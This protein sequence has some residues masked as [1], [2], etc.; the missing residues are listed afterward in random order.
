MTAII[1]TI[2][3]PVF[4]AIDISKLKHDVLVKHPDG[5]TNTFQV[6]NNYSDFD[7]FC[8]YLA[9]LNSKCHI[10]LEPTADYHRLIA[11]R[12]LESGH[13]VFL[14]STVA[15]AR[16]R[17][18]IFNSRDKNDIKDAKVI[19]HLLESGITQHYHDPLTNDLND[20]QELANTYAVIAYRRTQVLHSLKNHYIT[21]YFPE[22]EKYL[23]STRALW[24]TQTFTRFPT[25][26]SISTLSMSKFI[27]IASPLVGRKVRKNQWLEELY[28]TASHS[29]GLPVSETSVAARMFALMLSEYER[30]TLIRQQIQDTADT[31]LSSN[32]DYELLKSIPGVG[33]VI[34][35]S[36]LA[37]GGDLR[38]FKHHKQFLKF[39]GFDLA[40][41]QSG[42]YKSKSSLSKRGNARLRLVFWQAA[43]V[44]IR[45]TENSFRNK[46]TRYIKANTD[47]ADNRRK[48]R[49]AVAAKLARVAYSIVKSGKPYRPYFESALPGG[50]IP[51]IGS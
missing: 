26:G 23:H 38:R 48:A 2:S 47:T 33:P 31:V 8:G 17:E 11:W 16:A 13:E 44:A 40:T 20:L 34:A 12:L 3:A 29:I 5:K 14:V 51:Q 28:N 41:H 24:F 35:L 37:E 32:P 1:S 7:K 9:S 42:K 46:Y 43:T 25:P 4:V 10:A 36:I 19:M 27:A 22:I 21:L 50:K 15:C 45:Q 18:A 6:A 49:V 39:C 30:L